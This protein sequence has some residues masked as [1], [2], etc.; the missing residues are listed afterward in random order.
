MERLVFKID[1]NADAARVYQTI[2]GADTYP[3]WAEIFDPTSRVEGSWDEGSEIR[4][5]GTDEAGKTHGMI[6][7]VTANKP[8]KLIELTHQGHIRDGKDYVGES[9]SWAGAQ[10][11]YHLDEHN[12]VSTLRVEID[13]EPDFVEYFQ[14]TYPEALKRIKALAEVNIHS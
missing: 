12:G 7:K 1:I 2:I 4:F 13:S 14:K 3:Q 8:H 11:K 10:Q 6:S 9:V 5:V